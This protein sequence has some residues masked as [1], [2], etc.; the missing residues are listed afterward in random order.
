MLSRIFG[1]KRDEITGEWRKVHG[2]ELNDLYSS[3]K[4]FRVIKSEKMRLTGPVARMWAGGM[5]TRFDGEP[6]RKRPLG[7]ERYVWENNIMMV[8]EE[9]ECARHRLD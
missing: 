8:L 2:E 7:R 9:L 4:N 5:H 6:E 1:P 3:P